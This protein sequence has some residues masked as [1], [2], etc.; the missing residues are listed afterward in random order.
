MNAKEY[1]GKLYNLLMT[2]YEE[3]EKEWSVWKNATDDAQR[4]KHKMYAPRL[5][6]AVGPFNIDGNVEENI[7]RIKNFA[8]QDKLIKKIFGENFNKNYLNKNPRCFLAIEIGFSGSRK[9]LLGD[10]V[11][12][13][14]M[15]YIGLIIAK[16]DKMKKRYEKIINY[17]D[18]A[19][20]VG[21]LK[22]S[23]LTKN[24]EVLTVEEFNKILRE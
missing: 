5:D 1:Q 6:I 3:V 22:A 2:R 4:L 18:F 23:D 21:K 14:I 24:I 16:D 8:R 19:K 20:K 9:H 15:G 7:K 12:A 11:N 13:G 17:I 10:L